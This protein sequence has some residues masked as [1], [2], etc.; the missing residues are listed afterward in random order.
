MAKL[1]TPQE[2]ADVRTVRSRS[3]MN[4]PHPLNLADEA[5]WR[6]FQRILTSAGITKKGNPELL[7]TI[8]ESRQRH[9]ANGGPDLASAELAGDDTSP[10]VDQNMFSSMGVDP[11][12]NIP[13]SSAFSSV[14]GGTVYTLLHLEL[15]DQNGQSLGANQTTVYGQGENVPLSTA[16]TSSVPPQTGFQAQ[17]TYS[18]QKQ[19]GGQPVTNT[20]YLD[21]GGEPVGTPILT[22]PVLRPNNPRQPIFPTP[23]QYTQYIKIGLG[24]TGTNYGDC[25]YWYSEPD[26]NQQN[27]IL[28]VP[29]VATQQFASNVTS[30]IAAALSVTGPASGGGITLPTT[31]TLLQA[32]T[33]NGTTLSINF[34]FNATP[35]QD[36]SATFPAAPWPPDQLSLLT[37]TILVTTQNSQPAPV[38]V[39][40]YSSLAGPFTGDPGVGGIDGIYVLRP[41]DFTW[42]CVAAGTMV[43]APGGRSV[44]IEDLVGGEEVVIDAS[45]RTLVVNDTYVHQKKGEIIAI[46]DDQGHELLI[47]E[48][49]AVMTTKGPII[50]QYILPGQ[51]LHTETGKAKV[52]K[53]ERRPYTGLVYS[54]NVGRGIEPGKLKQEEM[55]FFANGILVGDNA[56]SRDVAAHAKKQLPNILA[57]LPEA[58]RAEAKAWHG[59]AAAAGQR[60]A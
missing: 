20:I 43:K 23:L 30:V 5:E 31:S 46:T 27:P 41:I 9:R 51:T 32:I 11:T 1:L 15:L 60:K 35:S 49:H 10:I 19:V 34:P 25:D 28:K 29:I 37:F 33:F 52:K 2:F 47:T 57:S 3:V 42:H 36:G 22:Q 4:V 53:V 21:V 13:T 38:A 58:W 26:S 24:R 8:E 7:R 18:Y 45:G 16:G 55:V 59:P 14:V 39:S 54:I 50:A 17:F 48:R 40:I 56:L 12:S 44:R 6:F